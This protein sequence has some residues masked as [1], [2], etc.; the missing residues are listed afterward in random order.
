MYAHYLTHRNGSQTEGIVVSQVEL[1]REWQFHDV[2][3]VLDVARLNAQFLKFPAIEGSVV[4]NIVCHLP[5]SDA[6][7][8]AQLLAVHTLN[9]RIPNH[10]FI[11]L[12]C[13]L[14]RVLAYK[15]IHKTP[16]SQEIV[17]I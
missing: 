8:L 1:V 17:S 9:T 7:H 10:L 2:V 3:N 16:F 15:S 5:E 13:N 11:F 14:F 12:F 6:L 4:I